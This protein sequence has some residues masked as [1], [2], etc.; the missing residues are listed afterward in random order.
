MVLSLE[1]PLCTRM[2]RGFAPAMLSTAPKREFQRRTCNPDLAYASTLA[3]SASNLGSFAS[4]E[5]R[6]R[7]NARSDM[8]SMMRSLHPL[9]PAFVT[10]QMQVPHAEYSLRPKNA[11]EAGG[12]PEGQATS[13]RGSV[14]HR[15]KGTTHHCFCRQSGEVSLF[16]H[17][18]EL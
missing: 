6:A 18:C 5:K 7:L 1:G 12:P 8:A 15:A 2:R 10:N 13:T 3:L 17:G 9:I 4:H 16:I 11:A 14:P